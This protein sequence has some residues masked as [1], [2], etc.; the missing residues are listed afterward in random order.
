MNDTEAPLPAD[1]VSG[2]RILL[3]HI[4]VEPLIRAQRHHDA[5]GTLSTDFGFSETLTPVTF[6]DAGVHF[7]SGQRLTWADA[8]EIVK[9]D[10]AC[11]ALE[12]APGAET[13]RKLGAFSPETR[14]YISLYP[15]AKAPTMLIAGALMHRVKRADP[16][17]DTQA[18][19]KAAS[20]L[21]NV[22]DLGTGLGYTAI[23][24][25][26]TASHVLTLELDPTVLEIA[27]EN[28]WSAALFSQPRIERRI[29]NMLDAVPELEPDAFTTLIHDPPS[30]HLAGDLYSAEFYAELLRVLAH[31][32]RLFHAISDM[33]SSTGERTVR[34]VIRRL[35]EVGFIRVSQRADASGV[36]AFKR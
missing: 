24:A 7:P 33:G 4:Q 27:A 1:G 9:S 36:I 14:R 11:F 18:K 6:S 29:A 12:G 23:G 22:L 34:G 16:I 15:T 32:G 28:P 26:R 13:I 35:N 20:P 17:G 30:L 19:L 8:R 2:A 31:R 5:G 3:S 25:A 21:G 10:N